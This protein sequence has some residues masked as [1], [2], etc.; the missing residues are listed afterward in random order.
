MMKNENLN[1]Q[2]KYGWDSACVGLT[3][4]P[5]GTHEGHKELVQSDV[6]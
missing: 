3:A 2:Y 5:V 4:E 1:V 6:D